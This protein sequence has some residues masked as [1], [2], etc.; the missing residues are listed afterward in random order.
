LDADNT[1]PSEETVGTPTLLPSGIYESLPKPE[2]F[3]SFWIGGFE[4][5]SHINP[6]G[7]RL[8]MI[9]GVQ[10]DRQAVSDYEL[11]CSQGM[12]TAR[13][14]VRWHLIDRGCGKYDFSSFLPMLQAAERQGIQVIW[15]LCHYGWPDDVDLFSPAFVDRFAQFSAAVAR[16]IRE[17]SDAVPFYT[18]INEIS[19]LAWASSRDVI[20]PHAHGRDDEIK[21]Q[22]AR[23]A[24]ASVE[25]LWSVDSRARI[26]FPEPTIHVVPPRDRPDLINAATAQ[27][28]GQWESWDI[29]AGTARP[30]LGGNPRYLD[31]I[32][33][34]YYH[35]NQW[36]H[37]DG[38]LRWEDNPLDDRWMPFYKMLGRIHKRYHR[39]LFV[40]ETS[41][42]GIGRPRWI[43]EMAWEV[44]QARRHGTPV[45]G[46]C[47][48]PILD[49]YDWNDFTH[50]HNSGFWDIVPD[51]DGCL[52][53]VLNEPYAAALRSS[54]E[55]LAEIGCV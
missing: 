10:H 47:M 9:A 2:L 28:H 19:F 38:R 29:I 5:A 44:Y 15:D 34:N 1:P 27:E 12:R 24:I 55:L 22:L 11:L 6:A 7:I 52:R 17:H 31:V 26:V 8:D 20:F 39:P 4:C 30:E 32:G 42:F 37:P 21:C 54:Q 50:W 41:H 3:K 48:Y 49:R 53:R 46:I 14:G 18:P 43:R 16:V 25:A 23:A 36:V 40:A 35:S 13:D 51:E 33:V 45:E